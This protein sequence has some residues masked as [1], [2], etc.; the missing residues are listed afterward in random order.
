MKIPTKYIKGKKEI[1][2][3][4]RRQKVHGKDNYKILKTKQIKFL[5]T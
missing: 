4:K 5:D 2:T 1:D 3:N